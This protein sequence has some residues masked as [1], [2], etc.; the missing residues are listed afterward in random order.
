MAS[1]RH[2]DIARFMQAKRQGIATGKEMVWDPH[3]SKFVLVD[4]GAAPDNL[5]KVTPEDLRAFGSDGR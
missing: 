1:N 2:D 3:T 4:R 5:P